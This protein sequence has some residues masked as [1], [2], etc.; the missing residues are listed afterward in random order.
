MVEHNLAK[1]GVA[2]SSPV[3]RLASELM[4]EVRAGELMLPRLR[5]VGLYAGMAKLAD[6]RDL[7]SL[8]RK[9]IRVRSPVPAHPFMIDVSVQS[10]TRP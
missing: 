2:G 9:A 7:K 4:F 5:S 1:V 8:G 10:H 3:S 6:A